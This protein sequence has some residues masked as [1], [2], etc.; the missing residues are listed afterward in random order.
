[1]TEEL[2]PELAPIEENE[3]KNEPLPLEEQ[4]SLELV[5]HNY[6]EAKLQEF[7]EY[8]KL[9]IVD[10]DKEAYLLIK[11]KRKEVKSYRVAVEKF[12]KFKREDYVKIQKAWVSK[13][14]ELV[15]KIS[16]IEDYLEGKEKAYEKKIAEEKEARK[17]KQEEQL[18]LRQQKLTAMG[19]LYSEG[20][21]ILGDVMF[22]FSAIKESEDDVWESSIYTHFYDEYLKLQAEELLKEQARKDA[23]AELKRQQEELEQKQKELADKEA[24]LKREEERQALEADKRRAVMIENRTSQI[25]SLGFKYN[26]SVE[27]HFHEFT[28]RIAD[29]HEYTNEE[30]DGLI[31]RASVYV[32]E[33]TKEEAE[34]KRK[35]Q[36]RKDLQNKRYAELRPF[37]EH[38]ANVAWDC[39]WKLT[40][41]TYQGVFADKKAAF[42]LAE[43]EKRK[44][45]A[46][47]AAK[48][49]RERI[50]EEQRQAEAKRVK[51]LRDFRV[52]ALSQYNALYDE[53]RGDLG[54]MTEDEW[55][56]LINEVKEMH[57]ELVRKQEEERKA[58]ELAK[59]GDKIKWEQIVRN[60]DT[61]STSL[62]NLPMRSSQYRKKAA[63][64]RE[65]L[66][67]IK[68]L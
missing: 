20:N 38:G 25:A 34:E 61:L 53:K 8:L 48:E 33:K 49:E 9:D 50:E 27:Y 32:T 37:H 19:A 59:S 56:K 68:A 42:D 3:N 24:E 16:K 22:E 21:F 17:R 41:E 43:E 29:V 7:E 55:W 52:A 58:E 63:I 14:N 13:E 15:D 35:E 11:D 4:V 45:I 62:E 6:T 28:I 47:K 64:L 10:G 51:E 26:G 23:E 46:E 67:E 39:L 65:K 40:E 2:K 30:W 18:I 44:A 31:T 1:M 57:D 12:C 5:K 54:E 36:E 66:E 60:I